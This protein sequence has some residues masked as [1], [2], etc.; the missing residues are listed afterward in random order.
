[1]T[2]KV[3]VKD[4]LE[5][6]SLQSGIEGTVRWHGVGMGSCGFPRVTSPLRKW[7]VAAIFVL[8]LPDVFGLGS[9]HAAQGHLAM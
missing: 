2:S 3:F 8:T 4:T 7:L 6:W 1:M 5:K 9:L